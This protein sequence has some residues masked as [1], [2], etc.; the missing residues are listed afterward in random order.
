LNIKE[1]SVFLSF[2]FI[3]ELLTFPFSNALDV[4]NTSNKSYGVQGSRAHTS[5][6]GIRG[7]SVVFHVIKETVVDLGAKLEKI[8]WSFSPESF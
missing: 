5:V 1:S 4:C 7:D 2:V 3:E 8:F 6:K